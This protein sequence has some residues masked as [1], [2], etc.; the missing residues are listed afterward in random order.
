MDNCAV[1]GSIGLYD[2]ATGSDHSDLVRSWVAN[3]RRRCVDPQSGL[4][5]QAMEPE[6]GTPWDAPRGSGTTLG[7]YFLSFVDPVLSHDLYRAVRK[8]LAWSC[9]GFGLVN[10]Y[11]HHVRGGAGDIDSG[12]VIF[13]IGLSP[14]GFAL[15]GARI[16]ADPMLYRRIHATAHL[17]GAPL[18]RDDRLE[19]VTGGPLGNAIM[20][21][22][23]TAPAS[24]SVQ[25]RTEESW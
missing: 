18:D 25:H 5:Y 23:L 6:N 13:G 4:L 24:P 20:F 12:P 1:I 3:C 19:F 22:M 8:E 15:S 10:E 9:A 21:A 11:P 7:L 14:T 17:F 2:Q 16:H